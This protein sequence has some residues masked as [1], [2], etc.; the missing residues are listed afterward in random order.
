[1]KID[2]EL[3]G[4]SRIHDAQRG[5]HRW[6]GRALA[7]RARLTYKAS[8]YLIIRFSRRHWRTYLQQNFNYIQSFKKW[9]IPLWGAH[10]TLK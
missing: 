2:R 4:V 8:G 5:D 6:D 3:Q 9:D 1:M 7:H 10:T